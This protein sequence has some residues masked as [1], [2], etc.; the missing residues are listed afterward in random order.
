MHVLLVKLS[1]MGDLIQA[2]PALTDAQQQRAGLRFDWA[3]DEQFAEICSWHPAVDSVLKSAHR[4][5]RSSGHITNSLR[6]LRSYHKKLRS[7][8][9]DAVIDAQNNLK[10]AL[11]TALAKGPTHGPDVHGVREWGA[12]FAYRYHYAVPRQQLA[13]DR[14]RQLF[15][16]IFEYPEP[17]SPP[18]FG[19]N[20]TEFTLRGYQ[21]PAQPFLLFVHNASWTSKSW[22]V[23]NWYS[24]SKLAAESNYQVLL[25]WG[26]EDE[27]KQAENI[28]AVS[29]NAVVLPALNLSSI[30]RLLQLSAGAIC[31]DTGLAHLS[32]ALGNKTLTLYG[33]TDPALIGATGPASDL[34][35]AQGF[36]C[37]PCYRR[38]CDFPDR[39]GDD[40]ACLASLTAE[41]VWR[42]F[43]LM[44]QT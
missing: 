13:I 10:S 22:P 41:Q 35:P 25:P 26:T 42:R 24:L 28:A 11:V 2:L 33:P 14:W 1:S 29:D 4:R 37:Q 34:L 9:Y 36:S 20:G 16:Q 43:E 17:N 18:D 39:P 8:R 31:M 7:R 30:A 19:I 32:A 27:R 5:W 38:R 44:A 3:V 6:E 12:H 40:A 15:A 23:A 21:A